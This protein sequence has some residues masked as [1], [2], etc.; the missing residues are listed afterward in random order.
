LAI[1]GQGL[2]FVFRASPNS[3][4]VRSRFSLRSRDSTRSMRRVRLLRSQCESGEPCQKTTR[5]TNKKRGLTPIARSSSRTMNSIDSVSAQP[6]CQQI[7]PQD[8]VG[9]YRVEQKQWLPGKRVLTTMVL[10]L[11]KLSRAERK[12]SAILLRNLPVKKFD[13][14]H[15]LGSR[16]LSSP[17]VS[18]FVLLPFPSCG[19]RSAT[20]LRP[21]S[22]FPLPVSTSRSTYS[23]NH[24]TSL[25]ERYPSA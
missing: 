15:E 21:A 19:T 3:N 18:T 12:S 24:R 23:V 17:P 20:E 4:L 16:T 11:S 9:L 8:L 10:A 1:W 2:F 6:L 25:V 14:D 7:S 22:R 5:P 13:I